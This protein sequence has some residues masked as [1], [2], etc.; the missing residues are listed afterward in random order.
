MP[1]RDYNH[2]PDPSPDRDPPRGVRKTIVITTQSAIA[3]G[4][5][6]T[7]GRFP[8]HLTQ[9]SPAFA[10]RTPP[11]ET[12]FLP[13]LGASRSFFGCQSYAYLRL[14]SRKTG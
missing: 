12:F 1:L 9:P 7:H 13:M 14:V 3:P 10:D 11:R 6:S 5:R 8:V 4:F 2:G